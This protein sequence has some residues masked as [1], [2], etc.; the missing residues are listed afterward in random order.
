MTFVREKQGAGRLSAKN[1]WLTFNSKWVGKLTDLGNPLN[2]CGGLMSIEIVWDKNPTVGGL[3]D[4]Q[5]YK[6]E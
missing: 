3:I 5:K 4:W 2:Q 1:T 6:E